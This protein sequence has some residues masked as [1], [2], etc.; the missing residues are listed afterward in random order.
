MV[1]SA[2]TWTT[3]TREAYTAITAGTHMSQ[4]YSNGTLTLNAAW[5]TVDQTYSAASTNAQSGT[6]VAGAIAGV[7]QVPIVTSND[8]NK[9]LKASYSGGVG[10]YSW[11]TESGGGGSY[12]AG[13]GIDITNDVIS[14]D[15]SVVATQ[16]DL[17]DKE[18][19]FDVGTGL[20][21]DTSGATP[22]L[23]VEAPVDIVAGP[24]IVVDNPD[25]NT[26]RVSVAQ[27]L[28]PWEDVTTDGLTTTLSGAKLLYSP[29]MNMC[30][31]TYCST[32]NLVGNVVIGTIASVYR[33]GTNY[34]P[35][36]VM[37]NNNKYIR[38]WIGSS[39]EV[40]VAVN[41]SINGVGLRFMAIW[42]VGE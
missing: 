41:E 5:P 16:T 36:T 30:M 18:D 20:E 27:V 14:M 38:G 22:T 42:V 2:N 35:A 23:Q 29:L 10:S 9:V 39:G 17:A 3:T 32:T 12:T 15:T 7:E 6:A 34:L 21:M 25:G 26:L 33:P 24:G 40:A 13:T 4:S 37:V 28:T 8:N 1:D 19:A 31:L 11:Q